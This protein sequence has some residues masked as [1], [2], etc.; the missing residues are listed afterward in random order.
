MHAVLS[1]SLQNDTFA[2]LL[3]YMKTQPSISWG[4]TLCMAP[5]GRTWKTVMTM[6]VFMA[7]MHEITAII[8]CLFFLTSISP[9]LNSRSFT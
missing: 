9:S 6:Q 3:H 8:Y 1:F 5:K 2:Y 4:H 7:I